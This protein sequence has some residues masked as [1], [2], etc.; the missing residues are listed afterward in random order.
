VSGAIES[1]SSPR[2]GLVF[3]GF[4]STPMA[5]VGYTPFANGYFAAL[6]RKHCPDEK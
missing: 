3:N 6:W 4:V 5:G 1:T 2:I